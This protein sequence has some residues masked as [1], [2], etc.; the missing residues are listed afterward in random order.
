ME[1]SASAPHA[2]HI[3]AE[4]LEWQ[5]RA[6]WV[7]A[8]LLCGALSFFFASFLFAYFYLR[9]L[10]VHHAWKLGH[11]NPSIGLGIVIAVALV[12]SAVALRLALHRPAQVVAL[13]AASLLLALLAIALQCVEWTTLGFGPAS[14]GYA[15][16]FVGDRK[17]VV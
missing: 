10:D 6:S 7:G 8:R 9:L 12:L 16:V 5:P 1:A 13:G 14:G 4:P 3:E 17:S 11:V 2:S 15:S